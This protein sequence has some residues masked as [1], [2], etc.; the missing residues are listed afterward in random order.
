M[1]KRQSGKELIKASRGVDVADLH[2]LWLLPVQ[3]IES[4]PIIEPS[5]QNQG[6]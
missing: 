6:Y 4:N 2:L 1:K 3:E 5:D